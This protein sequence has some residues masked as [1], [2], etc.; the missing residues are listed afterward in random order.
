MSGVTMVLWFPDNVRFFTAK[1][2]MTSSVTWKYNN[3]LFLFLHTHSA[4]TD[5]TDYYD[6]KKI[7]LII[8]NC[9][10]WNSISDDL[11][12]AM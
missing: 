5:K 10:N 11:R 7:G 8:T 3:I 4:S 9:T 2:M 6:A 12:A 1:F